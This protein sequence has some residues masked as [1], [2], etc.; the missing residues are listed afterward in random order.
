MHFAAHGMLGLSLAAL[1]VTRPCAGAELKDLYF[2]EALYH[3]YQGQFFEALQRLDVEL[4]QHRRVDE[5]QLDSLHYHVRHAEFS[6]GDFELYY[7]MH[8]RAGRAI[9][10]VLEGDVEDSVRNEAAFRLARIHFQK[11]Q[12]ENA[13][14]A[15][16]RIDGR[17]PEA[18]RDEIEFLRANVYMALGRPADAGNVLKRLQNAVS[19]SGFSAYNFGIALLQAG[20]SAEAL[21][22]LDRAGQ[23][24]SADLV[25][26][27]I[28][29]KSNMVL[30]RLM[31]ESGDFERAQQSFDRVRLEGPYSNQALLSA[32][33]A[34]A[35]AE[36]YERAIVPW[37]LLIER[38]VTDSAVQEARL[39]LPFAYSK[40]NVHGR[41]AL[42]YGNALASYGEEME[43]VDASIRSIREGRFLK[44]LVREEIRQ[45]KEWVVRLRSLPD[46]P[47]TFYLTALMASHDF[48]TAL[49]NYLDME[50]LRQKL[51]VWQK[52]FEAFDD[53][54]RLRRV[55]Y[56]ALLPAVDAQ[57]RELDS[58][59]RLRLEQR[60][61]L[62][63]RL[64]GLLTAPRPEL[65]ATA[66]ERMLH[67]RIRALEAALQR[68]D[69]P[70]ADGL[71]ERVQRLKGLL[72]WTLQREYHERLT[73]AHE[74]LRDLNADVKVLRERYDAFV[75]MRQAAT[76]SYVGYDAPM[77]RLRT[78]VSEALERVNT[79]MARQGH[80]IET[81]AISELKARAERLEVYQNQARY[82]MA[83]SYDRA[84]KLPGGGGER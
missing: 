26:A 72:D 23:I 55:N 71:R 22:Q 53:I 4:A 5:P 42:L 77:S 31:L 59:M 43:K 66:D 76:H 56:A 21:Q 79:L 60:D 37:N 65:L 28:R 41:A 57:F 58:H 20:R 14:H 68:I 74:H 81:V 45:D 15:L 47:E 62:E 30:G 38:D 73:Q 25:K 40:L 6:V 36:N 29:D 1:L 69:D 19:L 7:R 10:A 27:A 33:W 80:L 24:Q 18:I 39:A 17:V 50:D 9:R 11:G 52:G 54:I 35:A 64:Q 34:Y 12:P 51:L 16:E 83:D 67:N 44:A 70:A 48:Q 13:L 49:Q 63:R 61:N 2:G 46:A 82:A 78:R 3:A 8:H 84:T 32:G 75:R